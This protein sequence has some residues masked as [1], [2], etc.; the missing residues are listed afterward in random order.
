MAT[1]TPVRSMLTFERG[2]TEKK[3]TFFAEPDNESVDGE[4]VMVSF[5]AL[6]AWC[7]RVTPPRPG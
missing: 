2:D 1:S 5:E 7:R 3:F 4:T 6:P